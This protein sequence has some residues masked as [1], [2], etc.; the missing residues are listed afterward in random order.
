MNE[1]CLACGAYWDCEHRRAVGDGHFDID[2]LS[3]APRTGISH[4]RIVLEYQEPDTDAEQV[5]SLIEA[6]LEALVQAG[7]V[8]VREMLD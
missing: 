5:A 6:A 2:A 7:A 8:K 1:P 4:M 3:D